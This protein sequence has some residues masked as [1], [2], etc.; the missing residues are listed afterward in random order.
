[1]A[2][3]RP[4]LALALAGRAGG[5]SGRRLWAAAFHMGFHRRSRQSY[6][7][8][9][10]IDVS[11]GVVAGDKTNAAMSTR[12]ESRDAIFV[13]HGAANYNATMQI[14]AY[15]EKNGMTIDEV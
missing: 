13:V 9:V 10:A 4:E 7:N 11:D 8:Q 6:S 1:M 2:G 3:G 14:K 15:Q 12:S 5:R